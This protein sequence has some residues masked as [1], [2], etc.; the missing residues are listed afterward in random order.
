MARNIPGVIIKINGVVISDGST[1]KSDLLD[2]DLGIK[3]YCEKRTAEVMLK[4][5]KVARRNLE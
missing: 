3:K 5:L 4:D 2:I 1:S